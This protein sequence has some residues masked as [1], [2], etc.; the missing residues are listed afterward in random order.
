MLAIFSWRLVF[1][2]VVLVDHQQDSHGDDIG[3]SQ[4]MGA[5][6]SSVS[7]FL[8]SLDPER[9]CCARRHLLAAFERPRGC[10]NVGQAGRPGSGAIPVQQYEAQI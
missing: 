8:H 1:G 9:T 6:Q 10:W 3:G 5:W 7:A 4:V 2:H